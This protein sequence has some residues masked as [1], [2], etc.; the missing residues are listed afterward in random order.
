MPERS[1][2]VAV[3]VDGSADGTAAV[4]WADSYASLSGAT[5]RLVAA[6]TW[7]TAYA[8]VI[9]YE[10]FTPEADARAILEKAQAELTVPDA[11]I[12]SICREGPAG[13]ALVAASD[14]AELLVL[15]WHVARLGDQLLR[16]SRVVFRRDRAVTVMS[17]SGAGPAAEIGLMA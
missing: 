5:V 1:K 9:A 10:G 4:K 15:G 7:P 12:E 11:R 2:V 17:S 3:G 13:P 6:W 16:A 14:D 8:A